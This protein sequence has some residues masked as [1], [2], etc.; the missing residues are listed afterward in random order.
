MVWSLLFQAN[1]ADAVTLEAGLV[2]EAGLPP[3]NLKPVVAEFQGS[4]IGAF[5]LGPQVSGLTLLS[6]GVGKARVP[7]NITPERNR[8]AGALWMEEVCHLH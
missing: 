5:S 4:K 7:V 8:I 2:L 6:W 1:E 3:F